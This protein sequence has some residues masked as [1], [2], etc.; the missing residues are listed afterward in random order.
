MLY[1]RGS[2]PTDAD[3]ERAQ[4]VADESAGCKMPST[5]VLVDGG[6]DAAALNLVM[7]DAY[8]DNNIDFYFVV[9]AGTPTEHTRFVDYEQ[10]C[11]YGYTAFS[12]LLVGRHEEHPVCENLLQL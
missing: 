6:R 5:V 9:F 12:A 4:R 2:T 11:V 3:K 10:L 7:M 1:Y 8:L